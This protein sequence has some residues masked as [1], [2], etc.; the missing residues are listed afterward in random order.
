LLFW[1]REGDGGE[2]VAEEAEGPLGVVF[3]ALVFAADRL[4]E[5]DDRGGRG[6][7]NFYDGLGCGFVPGE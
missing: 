5:S 1:G 4:F 3:E 2:G 6:V 7:G